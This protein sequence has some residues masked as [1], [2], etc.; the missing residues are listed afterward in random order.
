MAERSGV[1]VL[2][3]DDDA[4]LRRLVSR[5]LRHAGYRVIEAA[6]VDAVIE[7]LTPAERVRA[8]IGAIVSDLRMPGL[9]GLDLLALLRC[10]QLELPVILMSS[11]NDAAVRDEA[12]SLGAAAVVDKPL[13]EGTLATIL[14]NLVVSGPTL[15]SA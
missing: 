11:F 14:A 5:E 7:R 9:S 15:A 10:A 2:V 4:D 1:R 3:A 6:N 8:P 12:L 13:E